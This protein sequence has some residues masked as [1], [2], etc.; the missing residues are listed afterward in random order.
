MI[1]YRSTPPN[2]RD[3]VIVEVKQNLSSGGFA[4]GTGASYG[5]QMSKSWIEFCAT[6]FKKKASRELLSLA[7]KVEQLVKNGMYSKA[8]VSF[9]DQIEGTT[10]TGNK[11]SI[12]INLAK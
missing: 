3:L 10:S 1:L 11:E 2:I 12:L 9:R 7:S 6:E 5:P 8:G 4:M